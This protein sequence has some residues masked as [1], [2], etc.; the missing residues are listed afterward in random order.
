MGSDFIAALAENGKVHLSLSAPIFCVIIPGRKRP[1]SVHRGGRCSWGVI[2]ELHQELALEFPW[3]SV[4]PWQTWPQV[5]TPSQ[6]GYK[7]VLLLG[8][9]VWAEGSHCISL[10]FYYIYKKRGDNNATPAAESS[11]RTNWNNVCKN[12]LKCINCYVIAK[13]LFCFKNDSINGIGGG[14]NKTII[15]FDE[16]TQIGCTDPTL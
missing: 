10:C 4:P 7:K 12:A 1:T 13:I 8:F 2:A 3:R 6:T 9:A 5:L 11:V 14:P 16:S 15:R